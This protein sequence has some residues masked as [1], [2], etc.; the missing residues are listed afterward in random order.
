[1]ELDALNGAVVRAGLDSGVPTPINDTIYA[2]LKRYQE[3]S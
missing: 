2:M 1:M 3:G